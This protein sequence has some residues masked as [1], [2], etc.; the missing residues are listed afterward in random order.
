MTKIR[1]ETLQSVI[2]IRQAKPV[3]MRS[4]RFAGE[5]SVRTCSCMKSPRITV[6]CD[7][8]MSYTRAV[9][10]SLPLIDGSK[11]NRKPIRIASTFEGSKFHHDCRAHQPSS[12]WNGQKNITNRYQKGIKTHTV[13]TW[14]GSPLAHLQ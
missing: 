11:A 12:P 14:N 8:F 2:G 9:N 1:H 10:I 3:D 6:F 4:R 13:D 5:L 7:V